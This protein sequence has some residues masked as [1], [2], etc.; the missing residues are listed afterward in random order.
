MY[1]EPLDNNRRSKQ[2]LVI[3]T[4]ETL[5]D[6]KKGNHFC[7][8]RIFPN[9]VRKGNYKSSSRGETPQDYNNQ[10]VDLLRESEGE[11]KN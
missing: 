1:R 4:R 3:G 5:I 9:F 11:K 6:N 2:Q 7:S 8:S 10:K